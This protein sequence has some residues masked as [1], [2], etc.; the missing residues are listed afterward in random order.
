MVSEKI[1]VF[2]HPFSGTSFFFFDQKYQ[3]QQLQQQQQHFICTKHFS[4]AKHFVIMKLKTLVKLTGVSYLAFSI[5]VLFKVFTD[6]DIYLWQ[7]KKALDKGRKANGFPNSVPQIS[8]NFQK[9]R[10]I[11]SK[12]PIGEQKTSHVVELWGKAAIG[13][14]LWQHIFEAPLERINGDYLKHGKMQIGN[15]VFHFRTG[16]MIIPQSVSE[17]AQNAVLF[18]NGREPKKVKFAKTWLDAV[19]QMHKLRNFAVVL[20]GN[21]QCNNNWLLPYMRING[22]FIKFAFIVY[23]VPYIDDQ[24]FHPWP[25]GVATYRDFP[26]VHSSHLMLQHK[27]RYICNFLGTVYE[28][29]SRMKLMEIINSNDL[30]KSSCFVHTRDN[31]L[32]SETKDSS[33]LYQNAMRDS[34]ITLCPVGRNTECYRIY[35]AMSYGSVPIVEDI[36]TPGKCGHTSPDDVAMLPLRILKRMNAPLIYV[37]SWTEL[38]DIIGNEKKL[39]FNY[40]VKRR[41]QLVHWYKKF[42]FKLREYFVKQVR[43][44]FNLL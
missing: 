31:W 7:K 10:N 29:S 22:G 3:Q 5:Y 17:D 41:A 14:Y 1:P 25:L 39:T 35:E 9:E 36:L 16:P 37:K 6:G 2:Y 26:V 4:G 30:V 38:P 20:L 19:K 44:G 8:K 12:L 40:I 23:D 42:K 27:R 32:P 43:T 15:L 28:N 18:I 24:N 34:D 21:E 13:L 33:E 11:E